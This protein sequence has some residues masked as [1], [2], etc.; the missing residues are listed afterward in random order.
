M[1]A[2]H[3]PRKKMIRRRTKH[4]MLIL[5]L[6]AA[7]I[8][9]RLFEL[10]IFAHASLSARVAK[11]SQ[12]NVD[13]YPQRGTIF[14]R[15]RN[16]LAQNVPARSIFYHAP[17]QAKP[18]D[19]SASPIPKLESLLA[20]TDKE[21]A[22]IKAGLQK[23]SAFIW[24][25][26]KVSREL[27]EKV[28][29]LSLPGIYS[30]EESKR[31]YPEGRLAAS[32][33][34]GVG[35]DNNG[36][37]GMELK[38]EEVLRGKTGQAVVF[39]DG[40]KRE[41][42]V[43]TLEEPQDGRD[44]VLSLDTTIQYIVEQELEK[45]VAQN[46]ANWGTAILSHPASGDI[47][48]MA[49]VP[50]FDPNAFPPPALETVKNLGIQNTFEPGSTFKVVTASSA[51]EAGTIALTDTFD[52]SR[53]SI[54]APGGPFRD[55]Q[56]FG[57]LTFPDVIIHSS[58]VGTIQVGRRIGRD[59]LFRTIQA[60]HFGQRTGI[61]LPAEEP[62]KVWPLA[63]W[64]RRSLDAASVGYEV[65]VTALQVLQAMNVIA[66]RGLLV[67][68][69]IIKAVQGGEART[70]TPGTAFQRIISEESADKLA[71]I[72][73]RVV[74]EGTGQ[75]ALVPGYTA[76]GKTGT[77]QK[78]DSSLKAYSSSKHLASF[79]G[80]APVTKPLFSMIIVLD[81]PKRPEYYAGQVVAPVFREI[82]RRVLRYL[83]V[84]PEKSVPPTIVAAKQG[85]GEAL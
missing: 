56:V 55:H 9:A 81:E 36:L 51:L 39:Q 50:S 29:A 23:K 1:S 43:E 21:I 75:E 65:S 48:A 45:A 62:G 85:K 59:A 32:V 28:E 46:Q 52:C 72:L 3:N 84:A 80:F 66:N 70:E 5:A 12:F 83:H 38:C 13:T 4:M 14:D 74:L 47:L 25:K 7:A 64:T 15:N 27:A 53:G 63:Q 41:F 77:S 34:G 58:N 49:S 69:H 44:I 10:Q 17:A 79:V 67:S 37:C 76:A 16:L 31:F 42:Y 35:T 82:S 73:E 6:W 57:V 26:R 2:V 30:Q 24:I 11:Q 71:G 8:F 61:E 60:F 20:L 18:A 19:Y 40:L 54:D 68:P 33:L 22:G 78:F